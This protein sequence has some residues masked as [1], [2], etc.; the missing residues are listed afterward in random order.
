[1]KNYAKEGESQVNSNH[2]ETSG[3]DI[4]IQQY[5]KIYFMINS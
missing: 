3:N 1:M 5:S 4:Y 2:S